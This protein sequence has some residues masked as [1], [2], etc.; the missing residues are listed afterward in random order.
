MYSTTDRHHGDHALSFGIIAPGVP[1]LLPAATL[2]P[3]G[4]GGGGG[5]QVYWG[6]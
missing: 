5:G 3:V 2:D 4:G 6:E 1:C